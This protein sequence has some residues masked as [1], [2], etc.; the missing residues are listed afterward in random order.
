[1]G[2]PGVV[3]DRASRRP[4]RLLTYV[5]LSV[6][7]ALASYLAVQVVYLWELERSG[8]LVRDYDLA[9]IIVETAT[10]HP[11]SLAAWLVIS[12]LFGCAAQR[13]TQRLYETQR[14]LG[15][16]R[17]TEALTDPLT[18]LDNRRALEERLAVLH[19][20][21]ERYRR[22][23]SVI[24]LDA[25]GLKARNDVDGHEAG[26]RAIRHLAYV[27]RETMRTVDQCVRLGGDEFIVL[28]PDTPAATA[29]VAAERLLAAL[30][31]PSASAPPGGALHASAGVA[32]WAPGLSPQDVIRR[33]DALLYE[34]KRLGKDRVVSDPPRPWAEMLPVRAPSAPLGS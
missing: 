10:V 4:P 17:E 15:E 5:L 34:A 14:R 31:S 19:P 7:L 9:R 20:L 21:V 27:L 30:R 8:A 16:Q 2:R 12:V 29:T 33:A 13:V 32:E 6:P 3:L 18:G 11:G 1:M 26:D 23:F 24:S 25:D 28:L 22:P